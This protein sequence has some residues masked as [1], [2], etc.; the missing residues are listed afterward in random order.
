MAQAQR[1]RTAEVSGLNTVST[2]VRNIYAKLGASD[3]SPAVQHARELR[4]GVSARTHRIP[5]SRNARRRMR[6]NSCS[7][8]RAGS[9]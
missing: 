1:I 5:A 7:G 3:R 8:V 4:P 9:T 6:W 2:H